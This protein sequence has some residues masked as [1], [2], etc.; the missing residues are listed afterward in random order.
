MH[1]W[2]IGSSPIVPFTGGGAEWESG[3]WLCPFPVSPPSR[4]GGLLSYSV[5]EAIKMPLLLQSSGFGWFSWF[6]S[7]PTNN[8]SPSADEDSDGT[9]LEV[10]G[11]E[12]WEA[13]S[14]VGPS[15]V[16]RQHV[17]GSELELDSTP[18]Q[19]KQVL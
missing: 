8:T 3:L 18:V 4:G 13:P 1:R 17:E 7:K 15:G 2:R 11:W 10:S 19:M 14:S 12:G 6:R 9:D 16:F 5:G